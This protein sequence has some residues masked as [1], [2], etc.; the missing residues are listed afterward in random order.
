MNV[1]C[2]C[3]TDKRSVLTGN[4]DD[5]GETNTYDYNDSFI[6]DDAA[7]IMTVPPVVFICV[8]NSMM[9]RDLHPVHTKY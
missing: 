5:D 4:S 6:D 1:F 8:M 7:G 2:G 9:I 3:S